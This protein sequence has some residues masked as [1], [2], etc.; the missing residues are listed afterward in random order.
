MQVY[1]FPP[2]P[3]PSPLVPPPPL[4]PQSLLCC[5]L[6]AGVMLCL[7]KKSLLIRQHTDQ[8]PG[9]GPGQ[10]CLPSTGRSKGDESALPSFQA[11]AKGA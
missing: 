10:P 1:S 6:R 8:G 5:R 7:Y 2:S 3:T 4:P 9:Q 11:P